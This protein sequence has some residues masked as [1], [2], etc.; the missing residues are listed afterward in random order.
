MRTRRLLWALS[1]WAIVALGCNLTSYRPTAPPPTVGPGSWANPYVRAA[2]REVTAVQL[3]VLD[4][5][6]PEGYAAA[7]TLTGAALDR[8]LQAL[9]VSV[10][11]QARAPCPDHVRLLFVR[12]DASQ[13]LL[14]AC[15]EGVVILRGVPGAENYDL[16]MYGAA[17]DALSAY[18]PDELLALLDF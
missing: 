12:P 7:G 10:H 11:V 2:L 18:L 13:V 15:L 14:S 1:F 16:P 5:S 4:T 17:S 3:Q 9:N 6:A 8:L